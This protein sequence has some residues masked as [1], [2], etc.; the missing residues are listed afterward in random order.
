M[1][2]SYMC[3]HAMKRYIL[4]TH[5]ASTVRTK[6]QKDKMK[7]NLAH[8]ISNIFVSH[9]CMWHRTKYSTASKRSEPNLP[10]ACESMGA[11][12][13]ARI[14]HNGCLHDNLAIVQ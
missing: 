8:L 9:I 11:P 6:G 4:P 1:Y 14:I 3:V 12:M 2:A 10:Q 7:F 5:L 13:V